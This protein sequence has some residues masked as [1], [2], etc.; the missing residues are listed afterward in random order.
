MTHDTILC[1]RVVARIIASFP[2]KLELVST[3]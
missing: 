1:Q 2:R 3:G